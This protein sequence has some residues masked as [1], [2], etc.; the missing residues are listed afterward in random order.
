MG[1]AGFPRGKSA[2]DVVWVRSKGTA[3]WTTLLDMSFPSRG[4]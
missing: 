3:V 2:K 1:R 4:V